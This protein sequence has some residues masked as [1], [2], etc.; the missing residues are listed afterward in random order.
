MRDGVD[1]VGYTP[2]LLYA[3]EWSGGVRWVRW[4]HNHPSHTP[5]SA[6]LPPYK[7][8]AYF[9]PLPLLW[10]GPVLTRRGGGRWG[11]EVYVKTVAMFLACVAT[12]T[13]SQSVSGG[14]EAG[15]L[16]WGAIGPC[17]FIFVMQEMLEWSLQ[18]CI[19]V[20]VLVGLRVCIIVKYSWFY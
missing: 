6:S 3:V 14:D 2:P 4:S 8:H 19:V 16:V 10:K 18:M 5:P 13:V 9:S 17:T 12:N 1:E 15:F 11:L 7:T 20:G